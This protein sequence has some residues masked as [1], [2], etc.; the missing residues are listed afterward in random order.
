MT[1]H[2]GRQ[3]AIRRFDGSHVTHRD[4]RCS[5]MH[6]ASASTLKRRLPRFATDG[7]PFID[8]ASYGIPSSP[9]DK[10]GRNSRRIS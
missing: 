7:R 4:A 10:K 1:P 9:A 8:A 3:A 6:Q 5:Q 2:N